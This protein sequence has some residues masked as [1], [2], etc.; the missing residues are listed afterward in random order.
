MP[1]RNAVADWEGNL[2]YGKGKIKLGSGVY[3]GSYSF[4]S[5]FEQGAGTNPEEL[6]AAA[7]AGCFSMAL[8]MILEQAGYV[9]EHIRTIAKV[10]IDKTG[11]GFKI[12]SIE[13]DT[14]GTVPGIDEQTFREKAEFAK[15][16]CPVSVALSGT[17]ITLKVKLAKPMAA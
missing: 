4:A 13:L 17:E 15:K 11:N 8:S 10:H 5:R 9:A 1:V 14:E 12:T 3:E 7:H 6:I 16:N 2:K